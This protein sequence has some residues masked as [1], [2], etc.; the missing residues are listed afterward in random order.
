MIPTG[1]VLNLYPEIGEDSGV[2]STIDPEKKTSVKVTL[3][4]FGV[5]ASD[6]KL[7][8]KAIGVQRGALEVGGAEGANAIINIF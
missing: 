7:L 4:S 3:T 1:W 8:L 5:I 2:L 6:L